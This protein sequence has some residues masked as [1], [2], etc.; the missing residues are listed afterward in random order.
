MEVSSLLSRLRFRPSNHSALTATPLAEDP[1][2][3]YGHGSI[4]KLQ[5]DQRI[6]QNPDS[7]F[8]SGDSSQPPIGT[9]EHVAGSDAGLP[10]PRRTRYNPEQVLE[11]DTN[12]SSLAYLQS[13]SKQLGVEHGSRLTPGGGWSTFG[14]KSGHKA[15]SRTP[16][17]SHRKVTRS[18]SWKRRL[19]DQGHVEGG[20][21][22]DNSVLACVAHAANRSQPSAASCEVLPPSKCAASARESHCGRSTSRNS[23]PTAT[24]SSSRPPRTGHIAG[25][26]LSSHVHATTPPRQSGFDSPYTFGH[27]THPDN[28]SALKPACA[29]PPLPPLNHPELAAAL[30]ARHKV[31]SMMQ[32]VFSDRSNIPPRRSSQDPF[33]FMSSTFA[34]PHGKRASFPGIREVFDTEIQEQQ[35]KTQAQQPSDRRRTRTVSGRPRNLRRDSAEWNAQQAVSGVTSCSDRTWP[36]EVSREIL[37]LSLGEGSGTGR[38]LAGGVS[39]SSAEHKSQTRGHNTHDFPD[40]APIS[41]SSSFFPSTTPPPE[42]DPG[43]PKGPV[44]LPDLSAIAARIRRSSTSLYRHSFGHRRHSGPSGPRM[45]QVM[46]SLSAI[47][48]RHDPRRATN[49]SYEPPS[50]SLGRSASAMTTPARSQLLHAYS[51]VTPSRTILRGPSTPDICPSR[52]ADEAPVTPT[53]ASKYPSDKSK[54]KRKADDIDTTPPELKKEGQRATF[55]IPPETRSQRVSNSS[56]APSSYHRKRARLST[57]SPFATPAHSRPPS[58]QEQSVSN[59]HQLAWPSNTTSGRGAPP[60]TPSRGASVRSHNPSQQQSPYRKS[61]D[62][63]QSMSQTSIPIS[64]LVSPHAPSVTTSSKFHMRDPRRPPKK[65]KDTEWG[66]RFAT[67]DEPSSPSQAWL[68]FIGFILFPL[69]WIAAFCIPIPK[70]R[71][72]GDA[73]LEKAVTVIDDPQIEHDAKSWRLRCR[74]MAVVSVFTYIPFIA[75]VA[76][77]ARR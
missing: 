37:R 42:R 4:T 31:V 66:L 3:S 51:A 60:R 54:G 18:L 77:F 50:S 39:G 47:D 27:P 15:R 35:R 6:L 46:R 7:Y 68:F 65:L 9:W 52:A 17:S 44:A 41:P 22:P 12:G 40:R 63:H 2:S 36:A 71:T 29:L 19:L 26:P 75:L 49:A 76:I 1:I 48:P 56:H 57:V 32:S 20:T 53:P 8:D 74:V 11:R 67:E 59:G 34:R 24:L 28:I 25:L 21:P 43:L 33:P 16:R 45:T 10:H 5:L 58:I 69:W 64:A 23:S 62:R 30:A 72:A 55:V 14:K 61:H 13:T 73:N 38:G 70:T